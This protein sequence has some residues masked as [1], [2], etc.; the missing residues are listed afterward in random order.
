MEKIKKIIITIS[1]EVLSEHETIEDAWQAKPS[2]ACRVIDFEAVQVWTPAI[3]DNTWS[4]KWRL[5]SPRVT[6]KLLEKFKGAN[7]LQFNYVDVRQKAIEALRRT[8]DYA[9]LLEI[10][11][12]LNVN[13]R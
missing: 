3:E 10:A 9:L 1:D 11:R 8:K 12:R 6:G 2:Y 5:A 13:V 4:G 7:P